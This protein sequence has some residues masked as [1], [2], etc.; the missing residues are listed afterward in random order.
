MKVKMLLVIKYDN[1]R[2]TK[3]YKKKIKLDQDD[4]IMFT[5]KRTVDI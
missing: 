3:L 5:K 4:I 2:K 1:G